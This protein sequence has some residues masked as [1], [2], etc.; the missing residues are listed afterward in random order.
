MHPNIRILHAEERRRE[1]QDLRISDTER[2]SVCESVCVCHHRVVDAAK[3]ILLA[4][5]IRELWIR[6]WYSARRWQVGICG[7]SLHQQTQGIEHQGWE[8]EEEDEEEEGE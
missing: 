4:L 6:D 1:K 3:E 5:L 8:E 2:E 7:L